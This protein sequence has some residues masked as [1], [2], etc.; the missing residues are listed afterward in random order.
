MLSYVVQHDAYMNT[1]HN[2]Q[3]LFFHSPTL[4]TDTDYK[5]IIYSHHCIQRTHAIT[6]WTVTDSIC[7]SFLVFVDSF[8][9]CYYVWCELNSHDLGSIRATILVYIICFGFG[10]INVD[11]NFLGKCDS[12]NHLGNI[13]TLALCRFTRLLSES[14]FNFHSHYTWLFLKYTL[15]PNLGRLICRGY[16]LLDLVSFA[17]DFL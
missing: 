11:I 14:F 8:F 15:V 10:E 9:H 3:C 2:H 4:D 6:S 13:A 1:Q 5:L 16:I 12:G 7:L 17:F